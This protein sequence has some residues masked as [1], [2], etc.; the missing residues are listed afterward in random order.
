MPA[1]GFLY[2]LALLVQVAPLLEPIDTPLQLPV[3]QVQ[4]STLVK[5]PE[6][7]ET[8]LPSTLVIRKKILHG[9]FYLLAQTGC[10]G[11]SHLPHS[12]TQHW[13]RARRCT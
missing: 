1:E 2:A 3:L 6:N 4:I 7:H 10:V 8:I 9:V 5:Q 13:I 12:P 11:C